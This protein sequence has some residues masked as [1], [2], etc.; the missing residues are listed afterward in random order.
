M[1]QTDD[2]Q[3]LAQQLDHAVAN[4][5]KLPKFPQLNMDAAYKVQAA[6]TQMADG[7]LAGFKAGLTTPQLQEIFGLD[8]PLL[9]RLFNRGR[10][11]KDCELPYVAGVGLECEMAVVI[12][13]NGAPKAMAPAIEIV[14]LEFTDPA[15]MSAANLVAGNIGAD[16]FI[17]GDLMPWNDDFEQA[18]VQLSR[19]G[20]AVNQAA[21]IEAIGG[22]APASKWMTEQALALGI[23]LEKDMIL[24]TGTCGGAVAAER[25]KYVADY[26]VLGS[27]SFTVS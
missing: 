8:A 21:L 15:D 5:E 18:Q 7:G 22:P 11:A 2:Y 24:M 13:K 16:R 17:I 10:L 4:R 27:I 9:G 19:D 20:E 26:G 23:S 3:T 6:F 25:G 1:T 12:D 14:Y